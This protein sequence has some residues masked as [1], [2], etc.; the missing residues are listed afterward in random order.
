MRHIKI[1]AVAAGLLAGTLIQVDLAQA[2]DV[3]KYVDE[4]GNTMYTDKPMPGSV[5]VSS[6]AQLP[7]EVQQRASAAQQ[8][9][10]TNQVNNT[11]QRA[12][13]NQ[14]NQRVAS[15]VAKDLESTRADRCK[16]ARDQY[17]A[18]L[19]ARRIYREND[20]GEREFLDE[21]QMAQARVDTLKEV[22]AICGPQG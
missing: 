15:Q 14:S 9:A 8:T 5:R 19:N 6:G 16:K 21:K 11:N 1:L 2:G 10:N 20:K 22:E 3:Y 17:Q 18:S 7:P 12:A 13:D 4:R